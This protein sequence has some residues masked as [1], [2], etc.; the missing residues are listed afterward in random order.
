[1]IVVC[2]SLTCLYIFILGWLLPSSAA[3]IRGYV[4]GREPSTPISAASVRIAGT[5]FWAVTDSDGFF[6]FHKVPVGNYTLITAA[7]GFKTDS[8]LFSVG[9]QQSVILL[10]VLTILSNS[11]AEVMITA[12]IDPTAGTRGRLLEK[13]SIPI[14]NII[15]REA[16]EH[17]SDLTVADIVQR[18]S[19]VSVIR[20]ETGTANKAIIRGMDPRYSTTVVNGI[21]MPG[22]DDRNRYLP[23]DIF[24]SVSI[25]HIEVYKT[26]TPDMEGNAIGGMVNVVTRQVPA[27][28]VFSVQLSTGY[29]QIFMQRPFLSFNRHAVQY[30][31][32]YE[33]HD[34]SYQATG[35]DFSKSNLSFN[36]IHPLPDLQ[37]NISWG[38][39]FLKKK[40]GVIAYAGMQ[41]IRTGSNSL[42]ITQ[43]NEPQAG[44]IPGITDFIKRE[45]S[46]TSIR[47]NIYLQADYI[48][49][50]RN[51][52][53]LTQFYITKKDIESRSAVDTSLSEGRS[54][55]GTGRIAL[56]Q[57]SRIHLQNIYHLDLHGSHQFGRD[58]IMDWTGSYSN[59]FGSYPDW[60]EL[61]ANTG[62]IQG[63]NGIVNQT[64]VLLATL[65]RI[66]LH[67]TEKEKDIYWNLHYKPPIL[68]QKMEIIGGTLLRFRSRDNFYN[69]Y[70]FNPAI[71]NGNGQPF[72]DIYGAQWLNNNGPQNP[73]GTV[74]TSG[75]YTARENIIAFYAEAKL[76]VKKMDITAGLREEQTIQ[77]LTSAVDPGIMYGKDIIISYHDWLPSV[78]LKYALSNQENIRLSY[79]KA[80]SRP[81]LYDIT[82]FNMDYDD[83][84]IAGNPFLKRSRADNVDLRYEIYAPKVVDVFQLTAF[85]KR[86]ADP[87]EKTLLNANDTL[88]LIPQQGLSYT[89]AM[90][91]TEQLKNFGA[92][93][94]YGFELSLVKY[95][96]VVGITANYT[97]TFSQITQT[98]KMK[99]RADQGNSASDIITISRQEKRP[100][101]GQSMHLANL[102]LTYRLPRYGLFSQLAFT[103]TGRRIDYVSG[104]YG[105]DNWRKGYT[106]L[107]LSLEK[108]LGLNWK[109][110]AKI[111]NLLNTT[112]SV[113]VRQP[114]LP[115]VISSIP[116]Q[117]EKDRIVLER[118]NNLSR[119]LIGV[120]FGLQ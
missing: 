53:R 74:N 62:R 68:K 1:M 52:L 12:N 78:H 18:V 108:K 19:G 72:T 42:L 4:K 31:S 8:L 71:T 50:E 120:Q 113:Y 21:A 76:Q 93:S 97:L 111:T 109:I 56:F 118:E 94:N 80:I 81:A 104:W 40:L 27:S 38:K 17:S 58:W 25:D 117:T 48:P 75:T 32:P 86:I 59:A 73:L 88:Y 110:F 115:G 103:Y 66:W 77:H 20:D 36:Q 70:I 47:K 30:K 90:K 26:L 107:D 99:V 2:R 29:S 119:C 91:L 69:N 96:G 46:T 102:G 85:Y 61:S 16:I 83:Y 35:N 116:G 14:V 84:N 43:N 6:V 34:A 82:F 5:H 65:N 51:K 37:G 54:G 22:S 100:L 112:T 41:E 11:L 49:N 44:N 64:P 23:L 98:K 33:L 39:R 24:P 45:Y 95:F 57:R 7:V 15:S 9:D 114:G 79:F 67:N 101:Q 60:A 28:P 105:L 10:P 87:F 63:A 13:N 106:T 92:A 3:T 89:P 55:P